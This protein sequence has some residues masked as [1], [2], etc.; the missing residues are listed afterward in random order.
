[1]VKTIDNERS[2][3]VMRRD[4][5]EMRLAALSS[6]LTYVRKYPAGRQK[7]IQDLE[8]SWLSCYNRIGYLNQ[9]LKKEIE[10]CLSTER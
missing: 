2:L 3:T 5:A 1:M 7:V 9:Q 10:S 6:T 4:R 8:A